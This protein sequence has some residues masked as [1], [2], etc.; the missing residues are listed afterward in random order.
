MRPGRMSPSQF[1]QAMVDIMSPYL[2]LF[3]A[4]GGKGPLVVSL[5]GLLSCVGVSRGLEEGSVHP[6]EDVNVVIVS[7][8]LSLS[9]AMLCKYTA[10][11]VDQRSQRITTSGDC[12]LR[13]PMPLSSCSLQPQGG[14]PLVIA[15]QGRGIPGTTCSACV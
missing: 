6:S 3:F 11:E 4:D 13:L 14:G 5:I 2:S 7:S 12:Y 1:I 8:L 9:L 10:P 15:L